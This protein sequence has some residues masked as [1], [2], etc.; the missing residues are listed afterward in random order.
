MKMKGGV[1]LQEEVWVVPLCFISEAS[2]V[3]PGPLRTPSRRSLNASSAWKETSSGKKLLLP[4][5]LMPLCVE[6][7]SAPVATRGRRQHIRCFYR[8]TLSYKNR[9]VKIPNGHFWIEGDHHGH[10][11]DSNSFG[12]VDTHTQTHTHS[13]WFHS[14][15][16]CP[17]VCGAP[18]RS[19]VSHYLAAESLAADQSVSAAEQGTRGR[20][21][22]GGM[23]P[24]CTCYTL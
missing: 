16:R 7:A 13:R 9:Y 22:R 12:P 20:R 6:N 21:G 14:R 4:T 17:G 15:L 8:R 2:S 3:P 10:S 11:L 23:K 24:F 1:Y 19:S 5:V 18:P